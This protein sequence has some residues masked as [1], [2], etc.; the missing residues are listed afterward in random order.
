MADYHSPT[1]V[2][3]HIPFRDVTPLEA[4]ILPLV[5]DESAEEDG[6][7]FHSWCGPSDVITV[8]IDAV[9]EALEASKDVEARITAYVISLLA[10]HEAIPEENRPDDLDIDLT[11]G[12]GWDEILQDIVRRSSTL[13]E[14]VVTAAFTCT[15]M[16]ADGFGGSV[17]R[18]TAEACVDAPCLAS[19]IFV[20]SA[21]S[22]I[23]RVSGL[24]MW[25]NIATG[26]YAVRKA[27]FTSVQRAACARAPGLNV[28]ALN[29]EV[30]VA[31]S[32][33]IAHPGLAAMPCRFPSGVPVTPFD[34][35][36]SS[37]SMPR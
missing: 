33:S 36:P 9:R 28:P 34:N 26:R 12:P 8:E 6:S 18:I 20:V 2:T 4:L 11:A 1:V 14:I 7:Y 32:S 15:K 31:Y 17:M 30:R 25:P 37:R 19:K 13:D 3:P 24:S 35:L 29:F 23:G 10:A 22:S 16:R 27:G 21:G 5:F